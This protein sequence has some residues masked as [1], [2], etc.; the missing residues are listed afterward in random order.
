MIFFYFRFFWQKPERDS[1][2]NLQLIFLRSII[3][4][5][6]LLSFNLSFLSSFWCLS[7]SFYL[8]RHFLFTI[9]HFFLCFSHFLFVLI[10]SRSP[11]WPLLSLKRY[12]D[13]FQALGHP[14]S[15]QKLI[16]FGLLRW[17]FVHIYLVISSLKRLSLIANV[18][19]CNV[20]LPIGF[21]DKISEFL[22]L[23]KL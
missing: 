20:L 21:A 4:F 19:L 16:F 5:L 8:F 12:Y 22:F 3:I 18:I 2:P 13:L 15:R 14:K 9:L 1:N 11:T 6:P 7:F 10:L 23:I 17:I